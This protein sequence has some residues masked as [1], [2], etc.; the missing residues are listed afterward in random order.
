MRVVRIAL[1]VLVVVAC[2]DDKPAA[3]PP[4]RD[5]P[6]RVVDPYEAERER[7]VR[8]TIEARG[9][10]DERVLAAMRKV[11]RHAFVPPEIR[12]QAYDDRALPIGFGLTISQPY[13]VAMMSEAAHVR[14]ENRVLEI[15]TGSG[16]QAA[17]LAAIGCQVYTIEINEQLAKRTDLVF[18]QQGLHTIVNRTGDGYRGIA[19]AAPFD[20]IL[21]TA[22]A[23][24]IPRPL[25]DQLKPG[26]RM[27]IPIGGADEQQLEVVT[28]DA[29]GS[30][31]EE[32]LLDVL[33][34]PMLGEIRK[35]KR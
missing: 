2:K 9:I 11:P 27:V 5:E 6:P 31:H 29:D 22:A 25:L 8:D 17:V 13:I 19:D 28:R 4:H 14:P 34:G 15:G 12:A 32:P 20:A 7:M 23:P 30:I 10:R 1:L 35:Q 24:E 21:V 3:P 33:F 16:Y 18:R 26:G